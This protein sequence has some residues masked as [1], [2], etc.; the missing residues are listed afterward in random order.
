MTKPTRLPGERQMNSY[1]TTDF[2]VR[3]KSRRTKMS[4]VR[5]VNPHLSLALT[6]LVLSLWGTSAMA[7]TEVRPYPDP[8]H[9]WLGV[10]AGGPK[11]HFDYFLGKLSL[12][13]TFPDKAAWW[14]GLRKERTAQDGVHRHDVFTVF[15][16]ERDADLE[17]GKRRSMPGWRRRR[18]ARRIRR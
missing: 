10:Y 13:D 12:G 5:Q 4:V 11:Q 7:E 18:I 9:R 2:Q 6:M 3:R 17:T 14:E 15:C 1:H 16:G 8:G